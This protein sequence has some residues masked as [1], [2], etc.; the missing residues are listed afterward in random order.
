MLELQNISKNFSGVQ[1]LSKVNLSLN[2]AEVVG[3][4][5]DNGAGKSTLIKI[6]SGNYPATSGSILV[7]EKEVSFLTPEDARQSGIEVVYQDLG[8]APNLNAVDNI[9]L[10]REQRYFNSFLSPLKFSKMKSESQA[11]L[12][13][14][15]TDARI[16]T[17][18]V[19]LS[20]GQRQA[21]AIART[22]LE[23]ANLIIMDE[24]LAAISIKQIKE[25]LNLIK[26]LKANGQSVLLVSH[27]LDDLF[28]V[29]DRLV[30]LRR[31]KKVAD[32]KID[33]LN[34]EEVTGL[35]TGA[36]SELP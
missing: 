34:L 8:L 24:P 3:L 15:Q 7:E 33:K 2:K 32:K 36:I 20:G 31:G 25:V 29:C 1:A 18:V 11:L 10:G 28:A 13:Q 5:G 6:I 19:N 26:T 35:I 4:I 12:N 9:F 21:I 27:R 17:P 23:K 16:D 30:V 14:I 22:L